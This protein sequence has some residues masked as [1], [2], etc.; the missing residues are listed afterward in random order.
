M[1]QEIIG[2]I[3]EQVNSW[4]AKL[5]IR[6]DIDPNDNNEQV[7]EDLNKGYV[8][9]IKWMGLQESLIKKKIRSKWFKDGDCNTTYFHNILRD[10]RR[11]LHLHR[12]KNNRD[13]WVQRDENI[14]M[15]ATRHFKNFFN[16]QQ[17][18][19]NNFITDCIPQIFTRE[20][21]D[22]LKKIPDIEEVHDALFS[23][24]KYSSAGPDGFNG[25]FYQTC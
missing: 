13:R 14:A 12:I 16:L 23:M 2:D 10:R 7:R 15:A 5:L 9:Y 3:N 1:V 8:E 25:C 17:P 11:R 19:A 6:E 18:T 21:N 24:R 20:D 4:E 22:I